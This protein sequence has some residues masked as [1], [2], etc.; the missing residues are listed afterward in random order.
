[1]FGNHID[2][3]T[4]TASE[5]RDHLIE[6]EAELEAAGGSGVVDIEAYRRDIEI[7][8]E[9]WHEFFVIAWVTE[10]ATL[11]AELSGANHG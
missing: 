6:L 9:R 5:A 4:M 1:M 3:V 2:V 10:I 8:I 11:R 7:E